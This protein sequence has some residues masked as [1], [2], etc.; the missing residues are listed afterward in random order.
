MG[1]RGGRWLSARGGSEDDETRSGDRWAVSDQV[2]AATRQLVVGVRHGV[3]AIWWESRL[4]TRNAEQHVSSQISPHALVR[5]SGSRRQM[6]TGNTRR[7][8]RFGAT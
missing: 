7:R 3:S 6:A 8:K 2:A 1:R 5:L 4:A